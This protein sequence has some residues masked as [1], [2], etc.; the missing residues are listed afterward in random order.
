MIIYQFFRLIFISLEG[1]HRLFASVS[2]GNLL[3]FA[4]ISAFACENSAN[5]RGELSFSPRENTLW[6][7]YE[8]RVP[9]DEERHLYLELSL[10]EA[11]QSGDGSFHLEEFLEERHNRLPVASFDGS[12][13]TLFGANAEE[14]LLQFHNTGH[15]KPLT[16][17]YL[18]QGFKG[19]LTDS[20]I[21]MIR[22]EPFRGTDLAVRMEGND[23]LIVLNKDLQP[24]SLDREHNLVRR[25]SRIFTIE[26]YFRHNGDSAD[27]HELNTEETWGV[28]KL[29]DYQTAIRQYHQL[30]ERKFEVTY[31]KGIGFSISH[32]DKLGRPMEALV[33][34]RVLQ[35]T[36]TPDQFPTPR[37]GNH[38]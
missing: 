21:R 36:S 19:N 8:G 18:I 33:I 35:M 30:T 1:K 5:T 11:T 24:V 34:K 2:P 31:M 32:T 16:R 29:G 17:K 38:R 9:V 22:E 12:Y 13:S 28:T 4:L 25:T 27:F 14:R 20:N 6:F 26:G 3:Y 10:S 7:V 37:Q 15:S 23:K